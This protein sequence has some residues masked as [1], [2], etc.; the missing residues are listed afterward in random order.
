M[1]F[2]ILFFCP[3]ISSLRLTWHSTIILDLASSYFSSLP[4]F[5]CGYQSLPRVQDGCQ[6]SGSHPRQEE[7]RKSK[8]GPGQLSAPLSRSFSRC[9]TRQLPLTC[10]CSDLSHIG[11]A[12]LAEKYSLLAQHL[13]P[14]HKI[15]VMLLRKKDRTWEGN[16]PS[17][18]QM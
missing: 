12:R 3:E 9:V 15:L 1:N 14:W 8:K 10:H 4:S 18:P 11:T 7:A 16:W 13:H 5:M 2:Q 17:L 6:S